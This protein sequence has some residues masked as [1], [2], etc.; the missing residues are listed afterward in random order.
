MDTVRLPNSIPFLRDPRTNSNQAY[1]RVATTGNGFRTTFAGTALPKVTRKMQR[2]YH[3]KKIREGGWN[4]YEAPIS[5]I[6]ARV[7]SSQRT[8]FERIWKTVPNN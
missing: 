8:P 6:N 7:H 1:Q 4:Q 5:F 3:D 2:E